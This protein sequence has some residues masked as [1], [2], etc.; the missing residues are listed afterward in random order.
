M[1]NREQAGLTKRSLRAMR[2]R[3]QSD[4]SRLEDA[5]PDANDEMSSHNAPEHETIRNLQT[6]IAQIDG[7]ISRKRTAS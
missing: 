7:I 5:F 6:A 2:T 1:S 3:W 4:L